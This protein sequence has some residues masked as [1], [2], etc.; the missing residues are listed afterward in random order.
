[1]SAIGQIQKQ[2]SMTAQTAQKQCS[3]KIAS[4]LQQLKNAGQANIT[5]SLIQDWCLPLSPNPKDA[6]QDL[7]LRLTLLCTLIENWKVSLAVTYNPLMTA[8]GFTYQG[9]DFEW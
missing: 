5:D 9:H 4:I 8:L 7:V 6:A 3:V 1:M 2:A